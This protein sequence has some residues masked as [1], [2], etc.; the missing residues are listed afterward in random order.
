MGQPEG[1]RWV[2]RGGADRVAPT[3]SEFPEFWVTDLCWKPGRAQGWRLLLERKS[4][5]WW[6][7]ATTLSAL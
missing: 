6:A 4:A 2:M 3:C 7:A 5:N 1:L